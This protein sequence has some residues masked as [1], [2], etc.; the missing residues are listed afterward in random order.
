MIKERIKEDQE[1]I[2]EIYNLFLENRNKKPYD[3]LEFVIILM[4]IIEG[5]QELSKAQNTFW[6]WYNRGEF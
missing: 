4:L 2:K 6:K 1:A 3:T 5:K